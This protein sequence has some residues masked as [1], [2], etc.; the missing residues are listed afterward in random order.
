M[1]HKLNNLKKFL[2]VFTLVL[3]G[4]AFFAEQLGL[5]LTEEME[6]LLWGFFGGALMFTIAFYIM[7]PKVVVQYKESIEKKTS[8]NTK[9]YNK[10]YVSPL[11]KGRKAVNA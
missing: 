4:I 6:Y 7:S 8:R 11:P 2:F 1:S 9:T 5:K 3:G 10:R